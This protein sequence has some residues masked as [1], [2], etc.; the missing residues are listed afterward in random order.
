M[1]PYRISKTEIETENMWK[2]HSSVD[3]DGHDIIKTAAEM[4]EP[5]ILE[6]TYH[7]AES[8]YIM[9]NKIS[10]TPATVLLSMN[11]R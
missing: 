4:M 10:K 9:K 3:G 11:L 2:G 8:K 1:I 6:H 5:G 7:L